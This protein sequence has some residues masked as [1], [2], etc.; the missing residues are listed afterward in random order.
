MLLNFKYFNSQLIKMNLTKIFTLL[1]IGIVTINLSCTNENSNKSILEND[2]ILIEA[3]NLTKRILNDHS[4]AFVYQKLEDATIKNAFVISALGEKI[5]IKGNNGISLASGLNWYL[6]NY[7]HAQFTVIDKQLNIPEEL[8]V[9]TSEVMVQTPYEFRYFFNICTF[10]YTMAW[11]D[12]K[13]WE[14]HID[15]MAM[16]GVNFPLAIT[17]QEAVWYEVY[18]EIGLSEDQ[19]DDFLVGPAYFPWG[20]MGNVDGLGG[21]L[22]KSWRENHKKLQQKILARERALGMTPI[23]QGFTGHVPE[24]LTEVFPNAKIHKTGDWS[25]GF[26]GTYF[27]DPEDE[28][29]QR[30]GKLFIE[31]QTDMYS[32]DHYYAADCFNEVN[33]DTDD[34]E[35]LA[36]MS[37]SVYQSMSAADPKAVWVMQAWF[38]YYQRDFWQD[39]QSKALIG[40]VPDDKMIILDLWGERFPTWETK[41]SFYGKPWIWNV[42][43]NFGGRTSMSGKLND[44]ADNLAK[45]IKSPE[46]GNFSG[47]GMTIEYF[48]NNPIIEEFVM[49]LVWRNEVPKIK[50]WLSFFVTNRYGRKN[51]HAEKAWQGMLKTVYNTHKQNGTFLCERPGFYNPKISYRSSPIIDYDQDVLIQALEELLKSSEDFKEL[52]TYQFDVVNLTRQVLSPLALKWIQD[53]EKAFYAKDMKKI[54][55]IRKQYIELITD[56]D[57][58]LATRKEFLL[59][60]WIE[61]AKAWGET[62]EEKDLY[63]W[64]A[65][66]LITLWGKECTENQYD[67]LNNY[68]LKQWSGMFSRY[69]LIR[70]MKF[71]DEI[72]AAIQRNEEWDRSQFYIESCEWEKE[73][74]NKKDLFSTVPKGDPIT[75]A[76][77]IYSKYVDYFK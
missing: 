46:K 32:T 75:A 52:E 27:L 17:G 39:P 59:G 1:L 6:K 22:P 70:W 61:D 34:P 14:R 50:D 3:Y 26:G 37:R 36:N 68:A 67:D 63:E 56:F 54:R 47:I 21:P 55:T 19:V 10:S 43:H 72:E 38:L 64:N 53:I 23:L 30:I 9:P 24:S 7:C 76:Q 13:D 60:N 25:A 44:V 16:N 45:V 4:D 33:P 35:F 18:T 49:D 42:L 15:W 40:A 11:W 57:N 12:W 69:H 2:P 58:L 77:Y 62:K 51:E 28:L 31:K 73:W 41:S 8:P 71:F 48:G 20:W 74:S 66:N 5:L 29:F 65:R